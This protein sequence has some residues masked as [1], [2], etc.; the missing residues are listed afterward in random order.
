MP[1]SRRQR[2]VVAASLASS[3]GNFAVVYAISRIAP[4]SEVGE[5]SLAF[6][7]YALTI[8]IGQAGIV[9]GAIV[10]QALAPTA[11]WN[12]ETQILGRGGSL[13]L[14]FGV[15]LAGWG[16]LGGFPYIATIGLALPGLSW[17]GC[18]RLYQ[19]A[20]GRHEV[21]LRMEVAWATV[22]ATCALLALAGYISAFGA[23]AVWA[24]VP[25]VLVL[26]VTRGRVRA[27]TP[28]GFET[29]EQLREALWFGGE[30]L[31]GNGVSHASLYAVG[32]LAGLSVLGQ[33]RAAITL[34][35]PVNMVL[36]ATRLL[37]IPELSKTAR[38]DAGS[39][40]RVA[41]KAT[42]LLTGVA[43]IWLGALLL[44]PPDWGAILLGRNWNP[45]V[46]L[47]PLLG[48]ELIGR[49]A[50]IVGYAGHRVHNAGER[51][52]RLRLAISPLKLGLVTAAAATGD[53]IVVAAAFGGIGMIY[54]ASWAVSYY[55]LIVERAV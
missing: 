26:S 40:A 3:G 17:F 53:P 33:V 1:T 27:L 43:A 48:L 25:Y 31:T 11:L 6:S 20:V 44:V 32:A 2:G 5:F 35:G 55:R 18:L 13:G 7:A 37:L 23:F 22:A 49:P 4:L 36:A 46:A 15:V 19:S 29:R 42:I 12:E 10:R 54:G 41:R 30:H 47:L 24:V 39:E 9:D 16:F 38:A 34:L 51:A 21:A 28:R 52:V 50:E 45:A 14:A 8:G